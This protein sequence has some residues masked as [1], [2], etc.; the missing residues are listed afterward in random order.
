M[1][2]P[3]TFQDLSRRRWS[4][5]TPVPSVDDIRTGALL[6]IADALERLAALS[7]PADLQRRA[8]ALAARRADEERHKKAAAHADKW[9]AFEPDRRTLRLKINAFFRP[10]KPTVKERGAMTAAC[11]AIAQYLSGDDLCPGRTVWERDPT[12]EE[13][14][15]IGARHPFDPEAFDWTSL[16][17]TPLMAGRLAEL[18]KRRAEAL[19]ARPAATAEAPA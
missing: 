9:A 1:P 16:R 7:D 17:L 15:R 8:D 4:P 5:S 19:A 13:V 14:L 10:A 11:Y 2:S 18:L 3:P 12:P 6:R